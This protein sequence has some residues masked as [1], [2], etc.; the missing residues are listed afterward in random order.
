[1][2]DLIAWRRSFS[3]EDPAIQ[4]KNRPRSP[5]ADSRTLDINDH[6]E[7]ASPPAEVKSPSKDSKESKRKTLNVEVNN[8]SPSR[9]SSNEIIHSLLDSL[10]PSSLKSKVTSSSSHREERAAS[11]ASVLSPPLS[12]KME[13][14]SVVSP[15]SSLSSFVTHSEDELHLLFVIDDYQDLSSARTMSGIYNKELT[16]LLVLKR[17]AK[18]VGVSER[19]ANQY[20]LSLERPS[21]IIKKKQRKE[22]PLD[23][24]LR[25]S[26]IKSGT[27][28]FF[29]TS[30]NNII[31]NI[32]ME[33][34][35]DKSSSM[36]VSERFHSSDTV[37][38]VVEKVIERIGEVLGSLS[39]RD[40]NACALFIPTNKSK[41]GIFMER[42]KTLAHYQLPEKATLIFKA[43]KKEELI[44]VIEIEEYKA[45]QCA[46]KVTAMF[47][48]NI[49]IQEVLVKIARKG[50]V[51]VEDV[52]KYHLATS[53]G[54][55]MAKDS[56]LRDY[57]LSNRDRLTFTRKNNIAVRSLDYMEVGVTSS[58]KVQLANAVIL[59]ERSSDSFKEQL[60]FESKDAE[61]LF[62]NLS[63]TESLFTKLDEKLAHS[64][65][66]SSS[67]DDSLDKDES[68]NSSDSNSGSVA[69]PSTFYGRP[70]LATLYLKNKSQMNS[71]NFDS[72][73]N[74]TDEIGYQMNIPMMTKSEDVISRPGFEPQKGIVKTPS[75]NTSN[76]SSTLQ[77]PATSG[78]RKSISRSSTSRNLLEGFTIT[79]RD[80]GNDSVEITERKITIPS[81]TLDTPEEEK[82]KKE[83]SSSKF[84][85]F[86]SLIQSKTSEVPVDT[87][88]TEEPAANGRK[89]RAAARG[90]RPGAL[91]PKKPVEDNSTLNLV[92]IY[93]TSQKYWTL[94]VNRLCTVSDI[95]SVVSTKVGREVSN[96][97]L[98][99][100]NMID[101][102]ER[103]LELSDR[104]ILIKEKWAKDEFRFVIR[105]QILRMGLDR[106]Q[107][108]TGLS[109][110]SK[111]PTRNLSN[112]L[113]RN[114][115]KGN[116]SILRPISQESVAKPP[117]KTFNVV[118]RSSMDNKEILAGIS[119]SLTK[120]TTRRRRVNSNPTAI[121][122]GGE[123]ETSRSLE[124]SYGV[125]A[126]ADIRWISVS[127]LVKE[128]KISKGSYA[129][130]YKGT[131]GKED[132]A[133]KELIGVL[134]PVQI[135][136]F[137][138][139][140]GI[141][142]AVRDKNL[143]KL[144]GACVSGDRLSMVMEYCPNGSLHAILNNNDERFDWL[145][146]LNW[147]EQTVSG[148][149]ALHRHD[150]PLVHR[151]IKSLNLLLD[152][153]YNIKICDFGLS[154]MNTSSNAQTLAEVRG[155][156]AFCPPEIYGGA[157]YNSKSDI[158]SL[159]IVMW[160]MVT[161]MVKGAYE[162]PFSEFP[163]ITFDFQ[164]ITESYH[165]KLRPTIPEGCPPIL[166]TLIQICWHAD[167]DKR[168]SCDGL[169]LQLRE[170]ISQ[171]EK[172]SNALF[173]L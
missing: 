102:A 148:I 169:L 155:T 146:I 63:M 104:L 30:K 83:T 156:M 105:T 50:N 6:I 111:I 28:L 138:V 140:M 38:R 101:G 22:L 82:P 65:S 48:L 168:P 51:N 150:P 141:L 122:I 87:K 44:L 35:G 26:K 5:S 109:P 139:E 11:T 16:V 153:M 136:A 19:D 58:Q 4:Q 12:P 98:L 92:C 62:W 8:R 166:S 15:T 90:K 100:V 40:K 17:V 132:V 86:A 21:L 113:P 76:T 64:S 128:K 20:A 103:K 72:K 173:K 161:R 27:T 119:A 34:E 43:R 78:R 84:P 131:Y 57:G 110:A 53:D 144:F 60:S 74:S 77:S 2:L 163:N 97:N 115:Q 152:S 121:I 52:S 79:K 18:K 158:Y 81:I 39:D 116:S 14:R 1:M 67:S 133:I 154:R 151:D 71:L 7:V 3:P 112:D 129:K 42:N 45:L 95:L 66:S 31:V 96:L 23:M 172:D 134:T 59:C 149:N 13:R 33:S 69:P 68:N 147:S 73:S 108:T 85:S 70:E 160:E 157:I 37:Q 107:S 167:P 94:A 75:D 9:S 125:A 99:E 164:I 24:T 55:K 54:R 93:Q 142:S 106:T 117:P 120:A 49:T 56:Y 29:G 41:T 159:G 135:A 47:N 91:P 130:V 46:R 137:K 88:S 171:T 61:D 126:S 32:I 127:D 80:N 89:R 124:R 123:P 165:N 25:E 170:I 162:T 143:V 36:S 145:G 10:S 114:L 118:R